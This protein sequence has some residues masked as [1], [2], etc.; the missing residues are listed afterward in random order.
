MLAGA[1]DTFRYLKVSLALV[2]AL[3]GTKML[4]HDWLRATLGEHVNLY[5][6][7]AVVLILS[8]GAIASLLITPPKSRAALDAARA[9]PTST[10]AKATADRSRDPTYVLR[11]GRCRAHALARA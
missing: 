5:V 1:L 10:F 3:V 11:D 2:L 6:L 4:A 9:G 8:A 7:G